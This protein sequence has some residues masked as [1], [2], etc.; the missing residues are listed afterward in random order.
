MEQEL[1]TIFGERQV[2]ELVKD[3]QIVSG[4]MFHQSTTAVVELFL[5]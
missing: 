3:D 4:Q 2:T 1:S 5:L